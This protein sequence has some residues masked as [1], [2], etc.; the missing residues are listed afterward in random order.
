MAAI[1]A[2][3]GVR[4]GPGRRLPTASARLVV[5]RAAPSDSGLFSVPA[6]LRMSSSMLGMVFAMSPASTKLVCLFRG[7]LLLADWLY[8]VW[9]TS[10][11][12]VTEP[13]SSCY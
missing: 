8:V 11:P 4:S 6:L 13:R 10:F 1:R 2:K 7:L 9:Y 12:S 5:L 3:Q